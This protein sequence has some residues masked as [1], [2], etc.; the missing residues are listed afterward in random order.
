MNSFKKVIVVF[1]ASLLMASTS[2]VFVMVHTCM[3]LKKT[4]ILFSDEHKCCKQN[5]K[6]SPDGSKIE[7]KCCTV[8]FQ[9]HKLTIVSSTTEKN[10]TPVFISNEVPVSY[11]SFLIFNN[12]NQLF[13]YSPPL[14]SVDYSIAFHQLLI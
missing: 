12:D 2:G 14:T 5:K 11:F 7:R 9:Y 8:D 1:L 13:Y 6:K 4:E 10:A 3:S